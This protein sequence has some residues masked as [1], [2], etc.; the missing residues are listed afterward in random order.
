[1]AAN[2]QLQRTVKGHRGRGAGVPCHCATVAGWTDHPAVAQLR[3]YTA[4]DTL[5]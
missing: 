3:R 2:K 4:S 5:T 1:M